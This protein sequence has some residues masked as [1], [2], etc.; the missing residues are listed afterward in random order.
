MIVSVSPSC[1]ESGKTKLRTKC[2]GRR[3]AKRGALPYP[4]KLPSNCRCLGLRLEGTCCAAFGA[5]KRFNV[6]CGA[7]SRICYLLMYVH[8]STYQDASSKR[9][10]HRFQPDWRARHAG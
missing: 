6:S 7:V 4:E 1:S 9:D 8:L 5:T 3:Q 2:S 10:G